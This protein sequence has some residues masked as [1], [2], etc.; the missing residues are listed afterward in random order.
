LLSFSLNKYKPAKEENRSNAVEK[1]EA[2]LLSKRAYRL[3]R[4]NGWWNAANTQLS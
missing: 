2:L 1:K 4:K 3:N